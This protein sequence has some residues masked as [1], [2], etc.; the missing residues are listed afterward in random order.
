MT[1]SLRYLLAGAPWEAG[2]GGRSVVVG[3]VV[4]L[5]EVVLV[6]GGGAVAAG[7]CIFPFD[8]FGAGAEGCVVDDGGA[9]GTS[10]C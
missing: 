10:S 1:F 2:L 8:G 6:I 3:A 7:V 9:A 4:E 5:V